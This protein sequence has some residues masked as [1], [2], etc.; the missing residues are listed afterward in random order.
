MKMPK[1]SRYARQRVIA[2]YSAGISLT[3]IAK[4]LEEEGIKALRS[5]VSLFVSRYQQT[6]SFQ[7]AKRSGRKCKLKSEHLEFIDNKMKENNELTSKELKEKLSKECGVEVSPTTICRVKHN[8]LGWKS[9]NARYCQFVR[10]PNKMKRLVFSLNAMVN[11]DLFED[12]IFTDETSVQIEQYARICFRKDG[13]QPKRK[14]CPKHP[15]KVKY[16]CPGFFSNI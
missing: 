3:K 7:A 8:E 10:E 11:K 4:L 5:A 16:Q 12:V 9:E 6:S 13:S 14:G 1:L 2:L 15:V